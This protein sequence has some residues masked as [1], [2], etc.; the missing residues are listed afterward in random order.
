MITNTLNKHR[1][2]PYLLLYHIAIM[3]SL[4]QLVTECVFSV[5]SIT[6]AHNITVISPHKHQ[7]DPA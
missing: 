6:T 2:G 7:H 3:I 1:F 5:A 4:A